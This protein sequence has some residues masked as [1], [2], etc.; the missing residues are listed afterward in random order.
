MD[1]AVS[2][3]RLTRLCHDLRQYV[4]AG[5]M[6]SEVPQD[7]GIPAETRQRF[8]T[9][10]LLFERIT[11]M[12]DQEIDEGKPPGQPIDVVEL[13]DEIVSVHTVAA[14]VAIVTDVS[15]A[16]TTWGDPVLLRRAV[17]NVLENAVRAAG[18]AGSVRVVVGS[19][20]GHSSIE[21]VDDGLGFGRIPRGSG[22]GIHT[23]GAVMHAYRG[24]LEIESGPGPG[25]TVRMLIPSQR[26]GGE[27][28]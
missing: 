18:S 15:G 17:G 16:A 13:V 7:E 20:A 14:G 1:D 5:A 6:I 10:V 11:S 4:A 22:H 28:A 24:R 9:L 25:T 3:E 26:D 21:V 2:G 12:I 27:S 8:E 23:V 19:E